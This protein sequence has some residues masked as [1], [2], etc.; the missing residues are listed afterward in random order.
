MSSGHAHRLYR[1]GHRLPHRLPPQ[2]KIVGTVAFVLVV[3]TTPPQRWWAFPAYAALLVPVAAAAAV[4][5]SVLVRRMGIEAPFVGFALLLPF[6]VPG[7]RVSVLGLGLSA[8]GLLGAWNILAKAT[9]GVL[10]SFLLAATTEPRIL[11]LGLQRL[12]LP[13]LIVAIMTFMLRYADVIGADMERMRIA[14]ESRGFRARDV[15]QLRVVAAAA[16][17]LFIRSYERGERVHLAMLSRGYTGRL[18]LLTDL[19]ASAGQWATVAVL[20]LAALAI[21]VAARLA[22]APT[23]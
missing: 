5:P 2:C 19:R 8:P 1:P 6:I 15:R 22:G 18:P 11:L 21:A 10:A 9:L 13:A 7:P 14:R 23:A 16:G 4:P 17:A 20:P 3:V 12:R